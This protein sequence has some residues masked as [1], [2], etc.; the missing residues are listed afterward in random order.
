MRV[1]HVLCLLFLVRTSSTIHLSG[2]SEEEST[3]DTVR[4]SYS[5]PSL[6]IISTL[7][8]V[9]ALMVAQ[10]IG[11]LTR[12]RCG[13]GITVWVSFELDVC[14]VGEKLSLSAASLLLLPFAVSVYVKMG[15]K[16]TMQS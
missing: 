4:V 16:N 9:T 2:A 7:L 15:K 5:S 10:W 11:T 12:N 8:S 1:L 14:C 6:G 3:M 13:R